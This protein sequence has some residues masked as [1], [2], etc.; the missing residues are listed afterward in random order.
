MKSS[1][2]ASSRTSFSTEEIAREF[3]ELVTRCKYPIQAGW[4]DFEEEVTSVYEVLITVAA[5]RR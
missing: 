2:C 5:T 1:G 4:H 3:L